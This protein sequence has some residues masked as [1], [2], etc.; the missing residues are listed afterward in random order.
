MIKVIFP[1]I[2]STVF[3]SSSYALAD[4]E[5]LSSAIKIVSTGEAMHKK[6]VATIKAYPSLALTKTNQKKDS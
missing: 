6:V 3:F 5:R 2:V 1:L 4:S